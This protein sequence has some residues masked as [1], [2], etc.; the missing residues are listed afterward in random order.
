MFLARAN[1]SRKLNCW[2]RTSTNIPVHQNFVRL[3]S[4]NSGMCHYYFSVYWTFIDLRRD[5]SLP[6][7]LETYSFRSDNVG[8]QGLG[9]PS[10]LECRLLSNPSLY[11]S[12]RHVSYELRVCE[13]KSNFRNE[14]ER[15]FLECLEF[16]INVPS[17]V[18]AKYY[19]DLRMLAIANDLQLPIHP[20]YKER[21]E[22]L[23]VG[24][25]KKI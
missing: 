22:K 21:A 23:E 14:L 20:L 5:R 17:S 10:C 25:C 18:Y 19:Y 15:Q 24:L 2:S 7:Q 8:L 6:L 16:N 1:S 4:I 12:R 13:N 3:C 11:Y 9:W